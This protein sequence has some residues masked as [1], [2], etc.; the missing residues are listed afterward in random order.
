MKQGALTHAPL[1]IKAK[2]KQAARFHARDVRR[3]MRGEGME[4]GG[5]EGWRRRLFSAQTLFAAR[6]R[7]RGSASVYHPR[8][9][10]IDAKQI[11]RLPVLARTLLTTTQQRRYRCRTKEQQRGGGETASFY[12]RDVRQL[13]R[14]GGWRRSRRAFLSSLGRP[15]EGAGREMWQQQGGGGGGSERGQGHLDSKSSSVLARSCIRSPIPVPL[16]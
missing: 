12:A 13:M 4:E 9:S 1:Q 5:A 11:G 14:G 15:D 2:T 3:L 10:G 7:G 8:Y 6:L 16:L